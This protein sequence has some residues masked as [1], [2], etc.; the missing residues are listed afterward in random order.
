MTGYD[1]GG[2]LRRSTQGLS[3]QGADELRR[4]REMYTGGHIKNPESEVAQSFKALS[5]HTFSFTY[6]DVFLHSC[7]DVCIVSVTLH[8]LDCVC[9]ALV[10]CWNML[11]SSQAAFSAPEDSIGYGLKPIGS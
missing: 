6:Y 1:G 9:L 2:G 8:G 4:Q 5:P 11:E 10:W 7:V 3:C